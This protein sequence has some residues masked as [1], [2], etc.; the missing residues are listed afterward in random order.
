[1][2]ISDVQDFIK[3]LDDNW[4][5]FGTYMNVD[6]HKLK[7]IKNSTPDIMTDKIILLID[8]LVNQGVTYLEFIYGL[9][10]SKAGVLV[11]RKVLDIVQKRI[12][13]G[14]CVKRYFQNLIFS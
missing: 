10:Q 13:K 12:R 11:V 6:M 7:E 5:E 1:M 14:N 2:E 4:F 3:I 8:H 9:H